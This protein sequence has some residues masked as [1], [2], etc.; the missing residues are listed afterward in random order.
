MGGAPFDVNSVSNLVFTDMSKGAFP[1]D[2]NPSPMQGAFR[3]ITNFIPTRNGLKLRPAWQK[4]QDNAQGLSFGAPI[5]MVKGKKADG[6][7]AYLLVTSVHLYYA[8]ALSATDEP[9]AWTRVSTLD[10]Y[11][12]T[13]NSTIG[14]KL[15]TANAGCDFVVSGT[16]RGDVITIGANS[17][18]VDYVD[19]S[20]RL[21]VLTNALANATTSAYTLM[22]TTMSGSDKWTAGSMPHCEF[23]GTS[24]AISTG[25]WPLWKFN[26]NANILGL[27]TTATAEKIL[28]GID[29]FPETFCF[30]GGRTLAGDTYDTTDSYRPNRLR[31][32]TLASKSDFSLSTNYYDFDRNIGRLLRLMP[33]G[34]SLV[35]YFEFAIYMGVPTNNPFAPYSWQR[36]EAGNIGLIG[37]RAVAS[38]LGVHYFV[39]GGDFYSLDT[40]GIRSTGNRIL[41]Q[42]IGTSTSNT[43]VNK[44]IVVMPETNASSIWV[45]V[46][47]APGD[48]MEHYIYNPESNAW[49]N[50]T[51]TA[52]PEIAGLIPSSVGGI[53]CMLIG[54]AIGHIAGLVQARLVIANP[55]MYI[56]RDK[57]GTNT[58]LAGYIDFGELEMAGPMQKSILAGIDLDFY[59]RNSLT[60]VTTLEADG[61]SNTR[62]TIS[63]TRLSIAGRDSDV[64]SFSYRQTAT[65]HW[66][67]MT[68]TSWQLATRLQQIGFR[69]RAIG[70]TKSASVKAVG[71]SG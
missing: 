14:S 36:I 24:F 64:V 52:W 23:D 42:R 53:N 54:E 56:E 12:G 1:Y 62:R 63:D 11:A 30:F 66:I 58:N 59:G 37:R 4:H 68:F 27:Y 31:W 3:W 33:L 19:T 20:T 38:S 46:P 32:S 70:M 6:T 28:S 13:V 41:S 10:Y 51:S 71:A 9:T 47:Q 18:E 48:L 22:R 65:R 57:D 29:F 61:D 44:N 45:S 69:A 49:T 60:I 34:T 2:D 15:I 35:A 39:G 43:G 55:S 17:Y 7:S 5:E 50:Y 21:F 25:K 67:T 26:P 40:Q 16:K 8:S